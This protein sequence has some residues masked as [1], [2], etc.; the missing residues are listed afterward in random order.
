MM[1]WGISGRK[2]RGIILRYY[3]GIFLEGLSKTTT[4][5]NQDSPGAENKTRDL[6]NTEWKY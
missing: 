2:R 6:T 4:I 5:L 1:K 3:S